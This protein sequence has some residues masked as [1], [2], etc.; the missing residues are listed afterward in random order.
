MGQAQGKQLEKDVERYPESKEFFS[1]WIKHLSSADDDDDRKIYRD[2]FV[3]FYDNR[4][5]VEP[6]DPGIQFIRRTSSECLY[7]MALLYTEKSQEERKRIEE[8][9]HTTRVDYLST[10]LDTI[11]W[12]QD[13]LDSNIFVYENVGGNSSTMQENLRNLEIRE[14]VMSTDLCRERWYW[15]KRGELSWLQ[16]TGFF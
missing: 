4:S 1:E 7:H 12:R 3:P 16:K 14:G 9:I 13:N 10:T 6:V 11:R 2:F 8:K 15:K 5:D